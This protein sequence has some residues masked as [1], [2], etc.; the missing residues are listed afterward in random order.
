VKKKTGVPY[1][2]DLREKVLAAMDQNGWTHKETAEFFGIGEASVDRWSSLRLH[3]GG[4][5]P[6]PHGGGQPRKLV[7][8]HEAVLKR[9]L[10][11]KN[12]RTLEELRRGLAAE[13]G[14]VVSDG[15][16]CRALD[17]L[18]LTLKKRQSRRR[19]ATAR[20]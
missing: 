20:T 16:I 19:S 9:L 12:D 3:T 5:V 15:T 8:K 14:L 2:A 11:E 4:V 13:T 7:E 6:R 1:S 18:N 17:R 10:E